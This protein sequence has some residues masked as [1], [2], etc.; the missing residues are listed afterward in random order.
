MDS[1]KRIFQIDRWN[2]FIVQANI[3]EI[4]EEQIKEIYRYNSQL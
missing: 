3:W 4:K 1:W 2:I